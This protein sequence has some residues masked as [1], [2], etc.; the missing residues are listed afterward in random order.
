[1]HLVEKRRRIRVYQLNAPSART[2]KATPNSNP[3]IDF[4]RLRPRY[5]KYHFLFR[6]S[7]SCRY[8]PLRLPIPEP[9]PRHN[10]R[11]D[12]QCDYKENPDVLARFVEH[13]RARHYVEEV[14]AEEGCDKS[15]GQESH[16]QPRNAAHGAAIAQACLSECDTLLG[17]LDTDMLEFRSIFSSLIFQNLSGLL[18]LKFF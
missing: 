9:E 4:K 10:Y 12:G 16:C 11:A 1:M 8:H 2:T 3:A 17:K 5:G 15:C 13:R 14:H 18:A 7:F 6:S